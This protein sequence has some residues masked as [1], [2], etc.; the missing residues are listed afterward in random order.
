MPHARPRS[1][2]R[3]VRCKIIRD[4]RV[5]SRAAHSR[6]PARRKLQSCGISSLAS[7]CARPAGASR[8]FC[9]SSSCR[10]RHPWPRRKPSRYPLAARAFLCFQP[11]SFVR[12][13]LSKAFRCPAS[14]RLCPCHVGFGLGRGSGVWN[15]VD[16]D[17][18]STARRV[19]RPAVRPGSGLVLPDWTTE[20]SCGLCRHVA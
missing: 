17:A 8:L 14:V 18:L 20:W 7:L 15:E 1:G 6:H 5:A 2:G 10:S 11:F 9:G 12:C 4:I 16:G 13:A 3:C 19:V